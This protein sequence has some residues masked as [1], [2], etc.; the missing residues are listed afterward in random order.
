MQAGHGDIGPLRAGD[1][2]VLF[3]K[4][5][6]T[7]E[8]LDLATSA[9]KP[10]RCFVVG[11]CCDPNHAYAEAGVD[12]TIVLPFHGEM[13]GPNAHLPTNSV[14]AQILLGNALAMRLASTCSMEQYA[15][16]HPAGAIGKAVYTQL[17]T[18]AGASTGRQHA[19][20]A[21]GASEV[22]VAQHETNM[23]S[24]EKQ[25]S[26]LQIR[27]HSSQPKKSRF[28]LVRRNGRE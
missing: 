22:A 18:T 27:L 5:G 26:D 9:L 21:A 24:V 16:N 4:S 20:G 19:V 1:I 3:S 25:L 2:T 23:D 28:S 14:V 6:R 12:L 10:R 7:A 8:L 13:D 11:V 15:S 17:A